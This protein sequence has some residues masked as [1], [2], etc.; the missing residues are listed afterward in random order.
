ME[1]KVVEKMSH[2]KRRFLQER[3]KQNNLIDAFVLM[4]VKD[5]YNMLAEGLSE[6][7]APGIPLLNEFD[8]HQVGV[9]YVEF[10]D[11]DK[12]KGVDHYNGLTIR[13]KTEMDGTILASRSKQKDGMEPEVETFTYTKGSLTPYGVWSNKQA[14][15]DPVHVK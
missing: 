15:S 12:I 14:D 10:Q 13:A 11:G 5:G 3:P 4:T 9:M 7:K 2:I 8:G 1:E 6:P